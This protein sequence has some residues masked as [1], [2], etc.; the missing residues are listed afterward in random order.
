MDEAVWPLS[1]FNWL[2]QKSWG[3]PLG[4]WSRGGSEDCY[5]PTKKEILAAYEGVRA[6]SEVIGTEA[7]LLLAP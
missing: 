5:T 7:Q 2:Q 4:F 6:A 1:G 3:R